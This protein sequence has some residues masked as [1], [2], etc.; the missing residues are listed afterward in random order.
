MKPRP[1]RGLVVAAGSLCVAAACASRT[2]A[3]WPAGPAPVGAD[4]SAVALPAT[5][6]PVLPPQ[7]AMLLG[8]LPRR[9]IGA[10]QFVAAHAEFDGRG[11]LIAI[12]DSGIDAG[13]PGLRRTTTGDRKLA[14]LRD[15]SGEGRIA[16]APITAEGDTVTVEGRRL[17]GFGRVVRLALPPYF[18]GTLAEAGLGAPPAADVNGDGDARDRLPLVVAK[19][20]DGWFVMADTDG[21]G[22]LGNEVPVRDYATAAETFSFGR[23]TLAA[24]FG[25]VAARPTL[26][27]F[28]DTSGHGSHVAGIAAGHNLF[29]IAG[30]DGIAPGAQLLGLKIANNARGGVSVTG[31]M[32]RAIAY[33]ADYAARGGMPLVL[34]L[35]YGVGN[36]AAAG[37]ALIDSV[38][39]AYAVEHPDVTIVISAGNDGPGISTI[40]F[41]GSAEFA[42]SACALFPGVF[43]R[44]PQ[45]GGRSPDDVLGWWSSRGGSV[46]KPDLCV[47]GVAFSNVPPWDEGEEVASGTSMAAPQLSGAAALLQS[48]LL[49]GLGGPASSADL[50]AALKATA[51]PIP[52]ATILDEGAGVPNVAAAWRWLKAGHRGGR[53]AVRALDDGGGV[54]WASAAY[55]RD[56]LASTGDTLQRFGIASVASPPP[57]RLL[58]RSDAPWLHAPDAVDLSAVPVTVQLTYAAAALQVPGLHVGTVWARPASDTL[59]GAVLGLTNT[60]VVPY[61]LDRPFTARQHLKAGQMAR[62]F[63]RVPPEAG[64]LSVEARSDDPDRRASLFLFEPSG[65]P[66]V[67]N[68]SGEVGGEPGDTARLGVRQDD[69]RAGVYEAVAVAP[70]NEATTIEIAAALAPARV[71]AANPGG[72]TLANAFAEQVSGSVQ[73]RLLGT[74]TREVV[75]GRG[76]VRRM[77]PLRVPD[78]AVKLMVDIQLDQA[79]WSHITDFAVS[80]WDSAGG[81]VAEMPLD[82]AAGRHY[83]PLDSLTPRRIGLELLPAFTLANDSTPWS[84]TVTVAFLLGHPVSFLETDVIVPAHGTVPVAWHTPASA[85]AEGFDPFVEVLLRARDR[86]ATVYRVILPSSTISA[87]DTR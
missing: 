65:R 75:G 55:R 24:N 31:A 33:A 66:L 71:A 86:P 19:A 77:L 37:R 52:G 35:S 30:F 85:G 69:L 63:F 4:E 80:L 9:A 68:P 36:D 45:A 49:G 70:P 51:S 42:L 57:G 84:A 5:G 10:E 26:D 83:L 34:N 8:L 73:A 58:L 22:S 27:L 53:F 32:V 72:V 60:V 14:D 7:A 39:D 87:G 44:P 17:G 29:G 18:G 41:P 40:G 16:L 54:S 74:A 61:T 20:S 79:V 46:Q 76:T 67:E 25:S 62:F 50:T 6:K 59:G 43:A 38:L 48:A 64:G 82:H 3:P 15:F 81:L 1:P 2:P 23:L 11:V 21:D 13:L 56:G 28:F 78:G 12:L 47:P